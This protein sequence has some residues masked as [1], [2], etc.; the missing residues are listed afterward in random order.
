MK[1]TGRKGAFIS[2]HLFKRFFEILFTS[3]IIE[4][5]LR[6]FT[7]LNIFQRC[8][9]WITRGRNLGYLKYS[10]RIRSIFKNINYLKNKVYIVFPLQFE[11]EATSSVRGY[12]NSNQINIIEHLSKNIDEDTYIV[13]KEHKGNEGY[14]LIEDYIK[15]NSYKNVI[16]IDKD[17]ENSQLIRNSSGI[18]T[19][20]STCF[21]SIL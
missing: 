8:K 19:I 4:S 18:I 21:R 5:E 3:P 14:R 9:Y 7:Q 13:V 2:N 11:P 6:I 1:Y 10:R 15:I 12:P 20:N 16:L 17:C